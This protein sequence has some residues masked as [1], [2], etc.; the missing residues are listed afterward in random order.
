MGRKDGAET[1][2]RVYEAFR[3]ERTWTQVALAERAGVEVRALRNV[4]E[5]MELAG[6]P[7]E[8]QV[9]HPHVYWRG[10]ALLVQRTPQKVR[11]GC[12]REDAAAW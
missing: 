9:D 6:V 8:R 10:A 11:R 4:L 3:K 7:L 5:N 1:M 2:G 12:W